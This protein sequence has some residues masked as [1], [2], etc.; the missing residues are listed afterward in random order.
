MRPT[1][2]Q[3]PDHHPGTDARP[4]PGS[5]RTPRAGAV[6]HLGPSRTDVHARTGSHTGTERCPGTASI[7]DPWRR[8]GTN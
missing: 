5:E 6:A 7:T 2:K 1:A 4:D 3:Y 8:P